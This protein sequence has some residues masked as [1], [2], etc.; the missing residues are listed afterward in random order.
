MPIDTTAILRAHKR[1][2]RARQRIQE[3][4]GMCILLSGYAM[5]AV[6]PETPS[7]WLLIRVGGGF[8]ALLA[9]FGLAILPILTRVTGGDE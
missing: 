8:V 7:D 9:G 4:V 2:V 6:S 1:K 3:I 5:L